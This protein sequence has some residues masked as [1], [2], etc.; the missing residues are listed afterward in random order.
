MEKNDS[1][2]L[3]WLQTPITLHGGWLQ[4]VQCP[5]TAHGVVYWRSLQIDEVNLIKAAWP[6]W[7]SKYPIPRHP[8]KPDEF[9]AYHL[10]PA[11]MVLPQRALRRV[12]EKLGSFELHNFN[13][14][15]SEGL[16]QEGIELM[17]VGHLVKE[18]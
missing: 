1:E 3:I 7:D 10:D 18:F 16:H 15:A 17:D 9:I 14:M 6:D 13:V 2:K 11:F 12:Y 5:R 8:F 4:H